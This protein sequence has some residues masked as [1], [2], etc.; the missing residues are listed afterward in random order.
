MSESQER[1]L[2]GKCGLYCGACSIFRAE[3]DDPE[4]RKRIAR[5]FDCPAEKVRCRGCGALTPE[6]WGYD[7]KFIVC[8]RERGYEY[9]FECPEY[10][11]RSCRKF[12]ELSKAYLEEDGVDLRANLTL[13]KSGKV[14]EWLEEFKKRYTCRFCE[15]ETVTGEKKCHHCNRELV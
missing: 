3:R 5:H 2:V 8:L 6:C 12:E 4:W 15:K 7:C 10:E 11:T 9:C 13:I 1:S 14:D